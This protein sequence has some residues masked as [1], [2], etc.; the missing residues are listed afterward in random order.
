MND[1][2]WKCQ[3]WIGGKPECHN[4]GATQ[5]AVVVDEAKPL[6]VEFLELFEEGKTHGE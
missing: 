5:G 2:C 3:C 4:C 1:R 6:D